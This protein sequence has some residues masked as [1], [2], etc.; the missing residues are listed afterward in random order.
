MCEDKKKVGQL[1]WNRWCYTIIKGNV[2]FLAEELRVRLSFLQQ[3]SSGAMSVS[4][5]KS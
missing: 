3:Q 5:F 1:A 4:E 2:L